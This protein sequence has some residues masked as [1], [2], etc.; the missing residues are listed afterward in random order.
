MFNLNIALTDIMRSEELTGV[1]SKV[2][3]VMKHG[4]LSTES[5]NEEKEFLYKFT[6]PRVTVGISTKEIPE[7]LCMADTDISSFVKKIL[8]KVN[9]KDP[10]KLPSKVWVKIEEIRNHS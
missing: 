5:V 2:K 3:F 8:D 10:L 6:S 4:N 9:C 7:A 1:T